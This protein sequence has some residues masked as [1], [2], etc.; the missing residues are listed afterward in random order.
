MVSKR[1]IEDLMKILL[2]LGV[3]ILLSF[4]VFSVLD[5]ILSF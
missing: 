1:G 4:G 2:W 3:L 5:K